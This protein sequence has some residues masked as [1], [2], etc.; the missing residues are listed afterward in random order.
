MREAKLFLIISGADMI[1]CFF[2]ISGADM[3]MFCRDFLFFFFDKKKRKPLLPKEKKKND[4]GGKPPKNPRRGWTL[5][6]FS[7][8]VI[9]F[10]YVAVFRFAKVQE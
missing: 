3:I 8:Y 2:I 4:L 5:Q 7:N 10:C 1:T 6:C 9:H